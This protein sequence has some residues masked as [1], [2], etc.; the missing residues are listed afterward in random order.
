MSVRSN[1][2][3]EMGVQG[4]KCTVDPVVPSCG[5]P[6]RGRLRFVLTELGSLWRDLRNH[7]RRRPPRNPSGGVR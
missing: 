6:V 1:G 3:K 5:T 4:N 7:R 2:C